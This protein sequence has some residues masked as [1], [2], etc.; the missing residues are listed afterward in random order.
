MFDL[1][2]RT[3]Y[4]LREAILIALCIEGIAGILLI[5]LVVSGAVSP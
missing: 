3:P 5:S 2:P 4:T 1:P